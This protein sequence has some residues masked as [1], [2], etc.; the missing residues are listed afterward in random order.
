MTPFLC[1]WN[2][3]NLAYPE[4][5]YIT[6]AGITSLDF[7]QQNTNLLAVG[8]FDGS[9]MVFNV[10][11]RDSKP[12]MDSA[13]TMSGISSQRSGPQNQHGNQRH[14]AAI[15][16]CEWVERGMG[17]SGDDK[18]EHLISI[19]ADG[20]VTQ[21]SIRKG[22]ENIDLMKLKRVTG[23]GTASSAVDKAQQAAKNAKTKAEK[24]SAM[25]RPQ[26]TEAIEI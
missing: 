10:K 17:T 1:C 19:S 11:S 20:R 16:Q 8:C 6:K 22:F 26:K 2:L 7:S 12:I 18:S 13:D 15:W 9:L 25:G 23:K 5:V 4:R 21:W 3:K 24:E 14:T